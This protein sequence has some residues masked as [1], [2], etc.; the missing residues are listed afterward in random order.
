VVEQIE[1]ATL[2]T[3]GLTASVYWLVKSAVQL[4]VAIYLD[5]K[6]GERDDYHALI[7]SLILA[8]FSSIAFV[9]VKTVTALFVVVF[10]KAVAFGFYTPSWT[11]IFSRHLDKKRYAFDWALDNAT[12]GIGSGI[13]GLLGGVL[14]KFFGFSAVFIL[15][16]ILAFLSV[17]VLLSLPNIIFPKPL[18]KKP[19]I[20]DHTPKNIHH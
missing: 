20:R 15:V 11:A 8:G 4:P 18:S 19:L 3:V 16:G 12:I 7:F 1:G 2:I 10:M 5:K 14:A 13:A 9:L 6:E 17:M